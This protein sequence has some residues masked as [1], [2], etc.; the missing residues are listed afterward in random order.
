IFFVL[1]SYFLFDLYQDTL[2]N[3]TSEYDDIQSLAL[4][5]AEVSQIY[6]IDRY[7]GDYLYYVMEASSKNEEEVILF[8]HQEEEQWRYDTFK[9]D[10]FYLEEEIL[11]E[12]KK[13]CSSCELLGST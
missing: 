3:K 6:D 10:P 7:H 2:D 8:M 1:L 9:S 4:D 13:R 12:W 11:S 5:N